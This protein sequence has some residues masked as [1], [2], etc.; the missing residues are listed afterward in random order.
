MKRVHPRLFD[1][2]NDSALDPKPAGARCPQDH[3][4]GASAPAA[5]G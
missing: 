4:G 3:A 1:A 2:V 5:K